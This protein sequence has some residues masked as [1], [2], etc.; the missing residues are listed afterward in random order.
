MRKRL[1]IFF[2]IFFLFSKHSTLVFSVIVFP[3]KIGDVIFKDF[4]LCGVVFA[5][6][7]IF[8]VLV[9]NLNYLSILSNFFSLFMCIFSSFIYF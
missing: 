3:V 6:I 4:F 1:T 9:D 7:Y 8:F 5:I 2:H